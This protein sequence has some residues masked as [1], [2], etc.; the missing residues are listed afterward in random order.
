MK[1][2]N[3]KQNTQS[4]LTFKKWGRKSYSLF[5]VLKQTVKISVLAVAYLISVPIL[6]VANEQDTIEVKM[7]Y[8]LDEIEVGAKRMPS[9]YS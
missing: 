1:E 9:L 8:D 7:Q 4:I 5:L 3:F 6:S 2:F